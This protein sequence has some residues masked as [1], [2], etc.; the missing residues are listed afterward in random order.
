MMAEYVGDVSG[1]FTGGEAH[2]YRVPDRSGYVVVSSI[3]TPFANE[4]M[5]F[6]ADED[7]NVLDWLELGVAYPSGRFVSALKNAGY[8]EIILDAKED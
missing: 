5:V 7:G 6:E 1:K 3:N 4:T 2:L 8:E